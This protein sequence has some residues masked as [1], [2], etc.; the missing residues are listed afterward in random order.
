MLLSIISVIADIAVFFVLNIVMYTDRAL[1]PNGE[2]REWH[3]N[4]IG[5][6]HAA[7]QDWMLYLQILLAAVSI[8]GSILTL[9][10]VKN[11][12]IKKV[13]LIST[14]ASVI[15]FVIIMVVTA[16]INVKYV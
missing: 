10:G 16:N 7:D 13:Q 15:M 11:E 8:I 9:F 1:M 12:I 2:T 3:R 4:P 5:R 6:L 14:V